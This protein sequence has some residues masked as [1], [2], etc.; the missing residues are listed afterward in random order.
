MLGCH[1]LQAEK[2]KKEKS[3]E[4]RK[5]QYFIFRWENSLGGLKKSQ[6]RDFKDDGKVERRNPWQFSDFNSKTRK[7]TAKVSLYRM[8]IS[9]RALQDAFLTFPNMFCFA[10]FK[11]S[12][13]TLY[14]S[15]SERKCYFRLI[16]AIHLENHRDFPFFIYNQ[17]FLKILFI[18]KK[19]LW[20]SGN[21]IC[22]RVFSLKGIF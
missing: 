9:G 15:S 17:V 16:L 8:Y 18:A 6:W 14:S 22:F 1:G 21:F 19:F 3:G 13:P 5:D 10:L 7:L 11:S 12:R 2:K 20:I 4:S